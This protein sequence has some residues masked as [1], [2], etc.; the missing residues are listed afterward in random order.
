MIDPTVGFRHVASHEG[1]VSV[2]SRTQPPP[3]QSFAAELSDKLAS[4]NNSATQSAAPPAG[5]QTVT[6]RNSDSSTSSATSKPSQ[7]S[8]LVINYPSSPTEAP[9][10][11]EA[12]SQSMF[13]QDYWASQP[14]AV[15][16]LQSIQD[17][18]Q[19]AQVAEQLTKQGYSVDVPIM[20]WGWDA[21]TTTAS[22]E[23]MG[24]TWVPSAG[25]QP[26][27]VA[28]G[29]TFGG[30]SYDPNNPPAGSITV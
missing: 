19:R 5:E 8:A 30:T 29:L 1:V 12:S 14:A 24:Y 26:V 21:A 4:T 22:R 27:E 13:D 20:V 11:T 28:P 17:P 18:T 9:A 15:Q 2:S 10:T 25:Q 7:L 6:R 23:A 16:Q 3:S